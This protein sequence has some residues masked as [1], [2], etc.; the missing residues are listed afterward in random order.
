MERK[1]R[2]NENLFLMEI[3]ILGMRIPKPSPCFGCSKRNW[4]CKSLQILFIHLNSSKDLED[5]VQKKCQWPGVDIGLLGY[6][7]C[8]V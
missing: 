7:H 6:K 5:H 8:S 1:G 2:F 4:A 3:S